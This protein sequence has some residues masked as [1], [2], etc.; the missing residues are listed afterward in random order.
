MILGLFFRDCR[1]GGPTAAHRVAEGI[2]WIAL[3][4]T[5]KMPL[6]SPMVVE[7][8]A[9]PGDHIEEQAEALSLPGLAKM[10]LFCLRMHKEGY[11]VSCHVG[12]TVV[13]QTI[14][15][16][17][18]RHMTRS[19]SSCTSCLGAGRLADAVGGSA[20]PRTVP[21]PLTSVCPR[22]ASS[23]GILPRCTLPAGAS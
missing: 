1:P 7:Q 3:Q 22:M 13:A 5:L 16:L 20:A 9:I 21:G 11:E 4:L 17:R 12:L 14:V 15:V 6:K 23:S 18:Q 2:K 19:R 10:E 8:A